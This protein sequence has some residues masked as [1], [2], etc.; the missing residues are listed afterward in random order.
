MKNLIIGIVVVLALAVGFIAGQQMPGFL[1]CESEPTPL[2][3]E[4]EEDIAD[5]ITTSLMLDFGEGKLEV[6]NNIELASGSSVFALLEKVI[7]ES[8]ITLE[9]KDYGGDMGVFVESIGEAKSDFNADRYWQYWVN[10]E[11]ATQGASLMELHDGDTVL[12]KHT[13]GQFEN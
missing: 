5:S 1:T 8:D 12:W 10:N 3:T 9:Y 11:Y 2:A 4:T 7:S 13:S 6:F